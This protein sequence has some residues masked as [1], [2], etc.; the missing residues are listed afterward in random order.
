M[1]VVIDGVTFDIPVISCDESFDFLDKFAERT[2]DGKLHRELIGVYYNY[3]LKLGSSLNT[4][5]YQRLVAKLKEPVEFHTVTVPDETSTPYTFTAYFSNIKH[6]L[7]KTKD[8]VNYW[9]G[10]MVNFIAKNPARTR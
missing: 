9:T 8:G 5:E 2:V 10:L 3:Q 1:S 6:S 7:R 4:A